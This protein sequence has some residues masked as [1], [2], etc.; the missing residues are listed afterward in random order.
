ML[1]FLTI[2]HGLYDHRNVG[3]RDPCVYSVFTVLFAV[4]LEELTYFRTVAAFT[5]HSHLN[6]KFNV[7]T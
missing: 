2:S 5:S 1:V 7:S 4:G 3:I 6:E